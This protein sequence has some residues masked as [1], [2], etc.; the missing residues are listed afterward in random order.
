VEGQKKLESMLKATAEKLAAEGFGGFESLI[1][2]VQKELYSI[3]DL[4]QRTAL[5]NPDGWMKIYKEVVYPS[6]YGKASPPTKEDTDSRRSAKEAAAR[7]RPAIGGRPPVPQD[8]STGLSSFEEY[9]AGRRKT[10][11]GCPCPSSGSQTL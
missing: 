6:V 11:Q 10:F 3:T 8:R 7:T 9:M 5:D 1:P 4:K 2:L